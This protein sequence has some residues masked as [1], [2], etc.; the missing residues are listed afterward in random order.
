MY[1]SIHLLSLDQQNVNRNASN[2]LSTE[3]STNKLVEHRSC[4]EMRMGAETHFATGAIEH[5]PCSE[6]GMTHFA[7]GACCPGLGLSRGRGGPGTGSMSRERA[8]KSSCT[9]DV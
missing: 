4:L 5:E 6:I 1:E 2:V 3:M 9:V 7:T 8:R